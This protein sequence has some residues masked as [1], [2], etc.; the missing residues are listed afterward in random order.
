MAG[1]W[2]GLGSLQLGVLG[3]GH[4]LHTGGELQIP[5]PDAQ[6]SAGTLAEC[7]GAGSGNM[8]VLCQKIQLFRY[9]SKDINKINLKIV[10]NQC[11]FI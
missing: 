2:V 7:L 1:L 8:K 10:V 4:P 3:Q 9:Q 5:T 11:I 6:D